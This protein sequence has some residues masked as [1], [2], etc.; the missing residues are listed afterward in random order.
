MSFGKAVAS[1]ELQSHHFNNEFS[2]PPLTRRFTDEDLYS[3]SE[4]EGEEHWR[5][6]KRT[7]LCLLLR[8]QGEDEFTALYLDSLTVDDLKAKVAERYKLDAS[9]IR[10]VTRISKK[11]LPIKIDD[12]M[13]EHTEQDEG[14]QLD[15]IKN[16][17]GGVSLKFTS[18]TAS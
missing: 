8:L 3:D 11:G 10:S 1:L 5:R 9:T 6:R 7:A 15:I 16:E 2:R 17:D 18:L 13:L 14:F 4:R 12:A